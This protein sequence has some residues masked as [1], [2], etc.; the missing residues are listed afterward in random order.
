MT[1]DEHNKY[2]GIG[3]LV[4]GGLQVLMLLMMAAFF[5]FFLMV[6]VPPGDEPPMAFFGVFFAVMAIF[7]TLFTVPAFVAGYGILK[8]KSWARMAA[9]IAGV[10]SAMSVP[11]G[12]AVTV[13]AYWFFFGENWKQIYEN[14]PISGNA[15][16]PEPSFMPEG[17]RGQARE[18]EYEFQK[19][20]Y[21]QPPDWR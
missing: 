16:L 4:H 1:N 9:I 13:Y 2:I 8:R 10:L 14:E 21:S 5:F 7:Q 3:F 15:F 12:T 11:I 20:P 19:N 17:A 6:S 18:A